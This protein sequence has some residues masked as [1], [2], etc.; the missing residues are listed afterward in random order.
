[1]NQDPYSPLLREY[2]R[3]TPHAGELADGLLVELEEQGVR[4]HLA[5]RRKNGQIGALRFKAWGCPH[6]I[7]ACECV[8]ADYEG[9]SAAE[10][11]TFAANDIMRKLSIPAEK[12]GRI[13][14]LEDAAQSLGRRLC[15]D[16]AP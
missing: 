5:G 15:D 12:T 2:F 7:A 14:V 9:R 16:A 6:L 8:C 13:L 4:V 11:A 10:L 3:N 1:M